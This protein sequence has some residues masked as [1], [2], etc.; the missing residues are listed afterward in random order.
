[1]LPRSNNRQIINFPGK[2]QKNQNER[3]EG[4]SKKETYKAKVSVLGTSFVTK[5]ELVLSGFCKFTN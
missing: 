5:P 2:L 3:K 1:M 4:F